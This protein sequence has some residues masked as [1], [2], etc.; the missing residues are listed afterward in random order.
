MG[1]DYRATP[2]LPSSAAV[3]FGDSPGMPRRRGYRAY[4]AAMAAE[5]VPSEGDAALILGVEPAGLPDGVM[6]AVMR[7][8]GELGGLRLKAEAAE[9][10]H[11]LAEDLAD[12]F[13]G[14]PCLN[15]HAFLRE[16]DAYIQA[17]SIAEDESIGVLALVHA[18]GLDHWAGQHG[19]HAAELALRHVWDM[20]GNA[21]EAGEPV[22]HLGHGMFCM[23][24][25]EREVSSATRRLDHLA[26]QL[27]QTP[28][29][30]QDHPLSLAITVGYASVIGGMGAA[31]ALDEA[32][33]NRLEGA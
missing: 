26:D 31:R 25:I 32:D 4:G 20:V 12:H 9:R 13:P 14:L 1:D 22:A 11:R 21:L 33:E 29:V 10:H 28:V 23:L 17:E 6:K 30:W 3:E 5:E 8:L 16:I 2:V 15:A 24:M 18:D 19:F 7:L 27:R